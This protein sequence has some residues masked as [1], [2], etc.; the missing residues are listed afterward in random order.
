AIAKD[1]LDMEARLL[2]AQYFFSSDN[3]EHNL[4]S[5]S[6]HIA[7]IGLIYASLPERQIERLTREGIDSAV[8]ESF[9]KEIDSAAFGQAKLLNTVASY[10]RFITKYSDAAEVPMARELR[11]EVAFL[12]ALRLNTLPGFGAYIEKYP[13]SR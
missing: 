5:A 1:S 9:H 8:I 2:M 11:N 10:E 13:D 6:A 12:D 7:R 4:D 3:P